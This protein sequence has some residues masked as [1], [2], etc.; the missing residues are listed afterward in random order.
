MVRK[1]LQIFAASLFWVGSVGVPACSA[2]P[3]NSDSEATESHLTEDMQAVLSEVPGETV[4]RFILTIKMDSD[5]K[6]VQHR[7]DAIQDILQESGA[8][9][10]W[11]EG[12]PVLF[13][14]CDKS[15]IYDVIETGY[16][17]TVQVDRLRKPMD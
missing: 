8:T 11:L 2:A 16:I 6:I 7:V 17:A 9:T 10:E 5:G 12:T 13:V 4:T 15:A 14:T 3:N 1:T